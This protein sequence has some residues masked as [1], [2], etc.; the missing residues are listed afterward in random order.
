MTTQQ[1]IGVVVFQEEAPRRLPEHHVQDHTLP[2]VKDQHTRVLSLEH[3]RY[4]D[5]ENDENHHNR[6][7][8]AHFL[9]DPS[10][11]TGLLVLMEH[12]ERVASYVEFDVEVGEPEE[13]DKR[14]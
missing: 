13:M 2:E 10:V 3:Q 4:P 12:D 14:S 6:N 9:D 8:L 7:I 5:Q 11:G 1:I